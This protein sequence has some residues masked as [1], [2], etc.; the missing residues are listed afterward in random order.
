[1]LRLKTAY[2]FSEKLLGA[3]LLVL[4]E[5]CM[6]DPTKQLRTKQALAKQ[7]ADMLYFVLCFDQNKV[8]EASLVQHPQRVIDDPS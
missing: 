6:E 1:M 7:F 3:L 4:P 2:E 5:L 8:R